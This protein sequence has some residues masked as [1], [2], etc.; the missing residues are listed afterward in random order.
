MSSLHKTH[1]ITLAVAI[2]M[3]YCMNNPNGI[4]MASVK[5]KYGAVLWKCCWI[6]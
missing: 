2:R 1:Q 4:C 3:A 6:L 5:Y